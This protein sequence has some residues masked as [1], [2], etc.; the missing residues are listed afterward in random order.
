[1]LCLD[2]GHWPYLLIK[3]GKLMRGYTFSVVPIQPTAATCSAYPG[4][5]PTSLQRLFYELNALS[6]QAINIIESISKIQVQIQYYFQ[7]KRRQ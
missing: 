3:P 7:A 4:I 2:T 5:A 1:M 6:E